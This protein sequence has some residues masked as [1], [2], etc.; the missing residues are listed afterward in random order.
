MALI[1]HLFITHK[2]INQMGGRIWFIY[3]YMYV[4][5]YSNEL[6]TGSSLDEHSQQSI[7]P[8]WP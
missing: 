6:Y 3:I 4:D 1:L 2:R 7:M 8:P 5:S